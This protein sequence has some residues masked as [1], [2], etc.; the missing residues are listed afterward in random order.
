MTSMVHAVATGSEMGAR[1]R[2]PTEPPTI[3]GP[4]AG[5]IRLATPC[6]SDD[7]F[8]ARF[9]RHVTE[10]SIFIVTRSVVRVGL[11]RPFVFQLADGTP[12]FQGHG[13]IV[14]VCDSDAQGRR[15][16]MTLRFLELPDVSRRLLA[17]MLL[18]N[19]SAASSA[20]LAEPRP[21][22]P[23]TPTERVSP[24]PLPTGSVRLPLPS[25]PAERL[26]AGTPAPLLSEQRTSDAPPILSEQRT[27]GSPFVLPA[28]PLGELSDDHLRSF[29]EC[30]LYEEGDAH[31]APPPELAAATPLAAPEAPAVTG[32]VAVELAALRPRLPWPALAIGAALLGLAAGY[33]LAA[34][35]GA[36]LPA[37]VVMHAP[38][39][40]AV[41]PV[42]AS[43]IAP[44]AAAVTAPVPAA[45]AANIATSAR[46]VEIRWNGALLGMS[47]LTTATVPCGPAEITLDHP[48][49]Q[50]IVLAALARP[51]APVAVDVVMERPPGMLAVASRPAGATFTVDGATVSGGKA[52]VRAYAHVDVTATLPGHRPWTQRVYVRGVTA[53]VVADLAPLARPRPRRAAR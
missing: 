46:D 1:R 49:Y 13:R 33:G 30:T 18:A 22:P 36:P 15:R 2:P 8:V 20:A 11:E 26:A 41:P 23:R 51:E 53:A 19:R 44:A 29:I 45:C 31:P 42:I 21:V 38:A 48:R 35:R 16:G 28:N 12:V 17:A 50:R 14:D 37:L 9:A 40:P 10:A 5:S 34:A 47:P 43:A 32:D 24:P 39:A 6:T 25:L 4:G 52:R 3:P 27:P 7:D